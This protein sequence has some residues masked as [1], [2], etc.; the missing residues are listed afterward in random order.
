MLL[1]A[2]VSL[3]AHHNH[4]A[5][6]DANTPV[7]L[8]GHIKKV[9]WVNPHGFLEIECPTQDGKLERWRVEVGAPT[10]LTQEGISRE[11]L[12][13]DTAITIQGYRAKNGSMRAWGLSMTFPDGA[14]K[15]LDD[16]PPPPAGG[17]VKQRAPSWLEQ[18]MSS[19]PFAPYLVA[20]VPAAVLLVGLLIRRGRQR[21]SRS[22]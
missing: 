19:V 15:R 20:V 14:T 10:T 12:A 18:V 16:T 6:Y 21:G 17:P 5:E 13:I 3:S 2:A 11:M 7:T 4:T 8:V 22:V 9:E 1:A